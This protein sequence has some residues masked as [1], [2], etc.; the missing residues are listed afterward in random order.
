[1][2]GASVGLR[3]V[4]TSTSTVEVS[5]TDAVAVGMSTPSGLPAQLESAA[6]SEATAIRRNEIR[7]GFA[8]DS[9]SFSR[10]HSS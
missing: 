10:H 8:S 1:M 4:A 7:H 9:N 3:V 6:T 2:P 5:G